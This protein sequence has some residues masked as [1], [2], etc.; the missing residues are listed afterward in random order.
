MDRREKQIQLHER[1]RGGVAG[2]WGEGL[3][4]EGEEV[5][6]FTLTNSSCAENVR[7]ASSFFFS[8]VVC[9]CA[10]VRAWCVC[11]CVCVCARPHVRTGVRSREWNGMRVVR[12]FDL[13]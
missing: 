1:G 10:C 8:V 5:V 12:W 13:L 7:N 4:E 3:W 2:G 9:M 11:L 6:R